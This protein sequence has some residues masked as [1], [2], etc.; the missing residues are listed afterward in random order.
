VDAN[1]AEIVKALR[2]LGCSV[3]DLSAVGGGCPDLLVGRLGA[4]GRGN[5]LVEIKNPKLKNTGGEAMR[6][7]RAKQEQF[8]AEWNGPT[9]V[10][11]TVEHAIAAALSI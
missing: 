6:K 1:Q 5:L 2:Q 10:V 7:T 8:R 9:V 4:S 3:L 11:E